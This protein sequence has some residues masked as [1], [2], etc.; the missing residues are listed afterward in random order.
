VVAGSTAAR[1]FDRLRNARDRLRQR[2]AAQAKTGGQKIASA[3]N[4]TTPARKRFCRETR[5]TAGRL[6]RA[7]LRA[8]REQLK[9]QWDQRQRKT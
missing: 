6:V 3:K 4:D 9:R 8:R 5:R 2:H 1:P 7:A